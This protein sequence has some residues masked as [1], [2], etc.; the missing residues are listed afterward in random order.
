M[1]RRFTTLRYRLLASFS[2]IIIACTLISSI[3][4]SVFYSGT[5][6]EQ[7]MTYTLQLLEQVQ[8]NVDSY[9][10]YTEVQLAT[11]AADKTILSYLQLN[12]TSNEDARVKLESEVRALFDVYM[13]ELTQIN[14]ILLTGENGRYLS[15]EFYRVTKDPLN[16]EPWYIAATQ[17][18]NRQTI[19]SKPI[20]RNLRNWK[21]YSYSDV[22]MLTRAVVDPYTGDVLGAISVDL[23]LDEIEHSL[24]TLQLG[25]RG[26]IFVLEETGEVVYAPTNPL[27]YRIRPQWF[28]GESASFITQVDNDEMTFLYSTSQYTG[29]KTIGMFSNDAPPA[30]VVVLQQVTTVIVLFT[31]AFGILTALILTNT[32]TKPISRLRSLIVEAEG[33]NLNV[34][35]EGGSSYDVDELGNSFNAMIDRIRALLTLVVEEQQQKRKVEIDALQAQINPHFLYNTLDT[36]HWLAKEYNATDIEDVVAAL[37]KLFRIGL[38]HGK[39]FIP[40]ADELTHVQSYLYIQKIRYEDKLN[41]TFEVD[42]SLLELTV[43]KLIVQPL[44]ENALYHGIK[45]KTGDGQIVIKVYAES[46]MLYIDVYDD[47]VGMSSEQR[48]QLNDKLKHREKGDGFG[49]FN[50]NERLVMYFGHNCGVRLYESKN[51][52]TISRLRHPLLEDAPD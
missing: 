37:T 33:G 17:G 1:T 14:G 42:E 39:E 22:A 26:V 30:A 44:V 8:R 46:D 11:L 10:H 25:Q 49:L 51:G 18:E 3:I 45:R 41:Y 31:L 19:V 21:I 27:V 48:D 50:V 32:I 15:N 6:L 52:E 13:R 29:W 7:N 47:G 16:W 36:I 34:H 28:S 38:S 40:L 35:Y 23:R 2:I 20:R 24:S 4:S 9:V 43:L 12:H 5:I